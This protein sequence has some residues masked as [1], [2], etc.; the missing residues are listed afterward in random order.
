MNFWCWHKRSTLQEFQATLNVIVYEFLTQPRS[1]VRSLVR[2]LARSL[3]RPSACSL[4]KDRYRLF[5]NR[6]NS[7]VKRNRPGK[8]EKYSRCNDSIR[9][10]F[11]LTRHRGWRFYEHPVFCGVTRVHAPR[12]SLC[13]WTNAHKHDASEPSIIV[14]CK[15]RRPGALTAVDHTSSNEW[16]HRVCSMKATSR[17]VAS[18]KMH[19]RKYFLFLRLELLGKNP[20]AFSAG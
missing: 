10:R 7:N 20:I 6:K 2:P 1:L 5:G 19:P 15:K 4:V 17:L 16:R 3:A 8:S 11:P 9:Q 14:P 13:T 18:S 12:C